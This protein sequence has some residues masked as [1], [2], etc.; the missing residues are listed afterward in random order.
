[1]KVSHASFYIPILDNWFTDRLYWYG[2]SFLR[3][4]PMNI[5][6]FSINFDSVNKSE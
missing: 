1:M 2:K 3:E 6:I 5:N 4:R